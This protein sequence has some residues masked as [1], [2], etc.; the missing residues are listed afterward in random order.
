MSGQYNE[1]FI[2]AL[3]WVWGDGYLSP[4]GPTEVGA[5][6]QGVE[7]ENLEIL[8]IGCGLGA[9]ALLLTEKYQA[10]SVVGIDIEPNLIEHCVKRAAKAQLQD[11]VRFKLVQPGPLPFAD[12]SFDLVFSK[13]AIIHIPDKES[14]YAD[15]L[16][17]LK[18]GGV[19]VGSDWLRNGEGGYSAVAA[20]WL[21]FVH[22]SFEMKNLVQ[23]QQAL[24]Q[25]GFE[26]VRMNDR[27]EWYKE[28]IKKELATLSGEK[29]A[30]L[31]ELIGQEAAEH[32]LESSKI[33]QQVVEEGFLRPT[34]FVTYKP[35]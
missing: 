13:D 2:A 28:E 17:I 16:R 33:K 8:D 25:A 9:I 15:V 12:S 18:P 30:R 29:F 5:L 26:R 7:V 32:R 1:R 23:T 21:E 31:A 14:L 27:N 35:V 19:F 10:K 22:L 3:Q 24:E 20:Q 4:G 11:R 6:L 34:H